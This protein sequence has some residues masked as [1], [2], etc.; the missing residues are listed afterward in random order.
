MPTTMGLPDLEELIRLLNA[1]E[2]T[3]MGGGAPASPLPADPVPGAGMPALVQSGQ[4]PL[5]MPGE[6]FDAAPQGGGGFDWKRLLP[7]LPLAVAGLKGGMPAMGGFGEGFTRGASIREEQARL[8]RAQMAREAA[9]RYAQMRDERQDEQAETERQMRVLQMMPELADRAVSDAEAAGLDTPD[10]ASQFAERRYADLV[11]ALGTQMPN[12]DPTV[13]RSFGGDIRGR[14][15]ARLRAKAAP[16]YDKLTRDADPDTLAALRA[17]ATP[18]YL[19]MPFS[20]LERIASAET[21]PARGKAEKVTPPN[22]LEAALARAVDAGDTAKADSIR[23]EIAKGRTG[24]PGTWTDTGRV[25]EQGKAIYINTKTMATK[26]MDFGAKPNAKGEGRPVLKSSATALA[27]LNNS[28]ADVKVLRTTV[29]ASPGSVSPTGVRAAVGAALPDAV[30][31][32]TGWGVSAKQKN[33][34]IA[35]VK[36]VIGKA[37]EGGVLRKEDEYKYAKILPTIADAP[38]VVKT[39]LDGL[40]TALRQRRENEL[41]ALED[42]GY[43]VSRF[44]ERIDAGGS[45][46]VGRF[47]IL[48]EK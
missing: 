47:E 25:N 17:D 30:T 36:Q 32:V 16:Y 4:P 14:V 3:P 45:R 46:K 35:R 5:D 34:V 48:E 19:G 39:K 20:E 11:A 1:G 8:K 43:D 41:E 6:S 13:L 22:S 37:L 31:S 21:P 40:E 27:E 15:S 24:E 28:L 10:L 23:R 12:M 38:E 29:T 9:E 44:R 18:R 7:L 2:V 26:A 42:A 33:A